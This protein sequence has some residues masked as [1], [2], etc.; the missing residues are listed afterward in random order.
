MFKDSN[1]V[2]KPLTRPTK[3]KEG[4]LTLVTAGVNEGT[5]LETF[6][7]NNDYRVRDEPSYANTLDNLGEAEKFPKDINS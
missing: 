2:D 3:G 5:S 1:K 6:R 7:N 4:R